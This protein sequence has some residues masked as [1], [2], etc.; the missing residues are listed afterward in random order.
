MP[1]ASRYEREFIRYLSQYGVVGRFAGSG[2]LNT[3]VGDLVM[4]P[5][6]GSD[7]KEPWVVEVK[8]TK[9]SVY[10]PSVEVELLSRLS[11]H[12]L[13]RPYL[14]VRFSNVGWKFIDL[15]E[16]VP[17]KVTPDGAEFLTLPRRTVFDWLRD[18][19]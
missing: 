9:K 4:L 3:I 17:Q 18:L 15:S 8:S 5:L 2:T 7:A 10:Y 6:R 16:G 14:A 11:R 1:K 13:F 19:E 12:F